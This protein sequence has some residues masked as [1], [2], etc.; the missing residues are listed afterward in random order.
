M[1]SAGFGSGMSR[2]MAFASS[3]QQAMPS[4]IFFAA[5]SRGSPS[6]MQPGR[7]GTVARYPPPSSSD[8]GSI[9][10]HSHAFAFAP[11]TAVSSRC[12]TPPRWRGGGAAQVPGRSAATLG[13]SS[14]RRQARRQNRLGQRD[15]IGRNDGIRALRDSAMK[16]ARRLWR[17]LRPA[18]CGTFATEPANRSSRP[19][20]R[21]IST[22]SRRT[23]RKFSTT[24]RSGTRS[25]NCPRPMCSAR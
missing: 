6:D 20:S 7:S 25:R 4:S 14:L 19:I 10:T 8:S 21:P 15:R 16:S 5:A 24:S 3:S 18:L 22:A 12:A 11:L 23:F 1:R 13:A 17:G 9:R 2:P